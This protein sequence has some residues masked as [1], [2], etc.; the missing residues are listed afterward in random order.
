MRHSET[1]CTYKLD[2]DI[3]GQTCTFYDL[4]IQYDDIC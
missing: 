4:L 3:C 2:V 1:I